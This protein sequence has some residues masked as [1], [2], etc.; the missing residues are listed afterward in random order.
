MRCTT[1]LI[2]LGLGYVVLLQA[3][4]E[5]EGLKLLGQAIGIL[6]MVGAIVTSLYAAKCKMGGFG[7]G[8]MCPFSGKMASEQAPQ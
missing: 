4:K 1:A 2:A 7:K 8:G 3:N 6:I 5:K